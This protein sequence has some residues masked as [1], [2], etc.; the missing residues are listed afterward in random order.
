[1][2]L[3]YLEYHIWITNFWTFSQVSDTF[4]RVCRTKQTLIL[5]IYPN[6]NNPP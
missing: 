3:I 1:M 2:N 6:L 4:R 5:R